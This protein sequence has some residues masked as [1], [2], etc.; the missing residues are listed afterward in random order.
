MKNFT[1]LILITALAFITVFSSG[2]K[3]EGCT[4]PDALN[5]NPEATKDCCCEYPSNGQLAFSISEKV[6]N[7]N[8]ALN[9]T[10]DIGG[11]PVA[12]SHTAIYLSNFTLL[13]D[14]G[15]VLIPDSYV[16]YQAADDTFSFPEVPVG[17]YQGIKFYV[18]IDST[19]NHANPATYEQTH[20]LSPKV[21][22]MHWSWNTGYIFLRFDGEVDT[23]QPSDNILDEGLAFHIGS[24]PFLTEIEFSKNFTIEDGAKRELQMEL[25]YAQFFDNITLREEYVTHTSDFPD[26]ANKFRLNMDQPFSLQ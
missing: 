11:V 23:S 13:A 22:N 6:G 10:F 21:P 2:C 15:E 12:F 3:K 26:L 8:F 14:T 25:D 18:G 1:P 16:L 19:T 17:E 9:Q 4:D 5:Y 20:P 24:D 7:D